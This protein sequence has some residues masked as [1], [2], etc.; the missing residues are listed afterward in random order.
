MTFPE[1]RFVK[2]PNPMSRSKLQSRI[3]LPIFS[4]IPNSGLQK[5]Q[6]SD[7]EKPIGDS[8]LSVITKNVPLRGPET[9][10]TM[11]FIGLYKSHEQMFHRVNIKKKSVWQ[12]LFGH[13]QPPCSLTLK[14]VVLRS[15]PIPFPDLKHVGAFFLKLKFRV[16]CYS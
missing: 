15:P 8:Q 3:S 11:T 9:E 4:K 5:K 13:V 6:I 14:C 16:F 10:M 12:T 7:P 1:S 2:L